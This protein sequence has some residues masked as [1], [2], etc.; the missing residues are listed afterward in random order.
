VY[1]S[2]IIT[3]YPIIL[4]S[5]NLLTI[6]SAIIVSKLVTTIKPI[7]LDKKRKSLKEKAKFR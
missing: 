4:I 6:T 5:I 2:L 7:A 1:L 3:T